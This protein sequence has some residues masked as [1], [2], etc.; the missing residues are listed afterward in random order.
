MARVINPI[1]IVNAKLGAVTIDRL[2]MVFAVEYDL[3]GITRANITVQAPPED[4]ADF[5]MG[6]NSRTTYPLANNVTN[7]VDYVFSA[8]PNLTDIYIFSL[9]EVSIAA[10]AFTGLNSLARIWVSASLLDTYKTDYPALSS[11]FVSV[12]EDYTLNIPYIA[13]EST[14]LTLEYFMQIV[15]GL[16][17]Q[18]KNAI[19][20]VVFD[21]DFTQASVDALVW[22][23]NFSNIFSSLEQNIW[24]GETKYDFSE[25]EF[26]GSGQ[27]T[28]QFVEDT[29]E[30]A[31]S[32]DKLS[33]IEK[34]TVPVDFTSYES[35]SIAKIEELFTNMTHLVTTYPDGILD[36]DFEDSDWIEIL[37]RVANQ[38]KT[39]DSCLVSARNFV[40]TNDKITDYADKENLCIVPPRVFNGNPNGYVSGLTSSTANPYVV[41]I[42]NQTITNELGFQYIMWSQSNLYK[43]EFT[44]K[45]SILFEFTSENVNLIKFNWEKGTPENQTFNQNYG[46][47]RKNY[48][49]IFN[50]LT[51]SFRFDSTVSTS[52][53]NTTAWHNLIVSLGTPTTTQTIT[54]APNEL[55]K[56]AQEDIALAQS[57]N[58]QIVTA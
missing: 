26:V 37:S 29:L 2:G 4:V 39:L 12:I 51:S 48:N 33:L 49:Y 31:I 21:D 44:F 40:N 17:S 5:L 3:D 13:G 16:T 58:W 57:K 18:Q 22:A 53:L 46:I 56:I 34:L 43:C 55:S 1:R 42:A 25:Y 54:V 32:S 41:Y 30:N 24:Y 38:N 19:T 52:Y 27:L 50:G 6:D 20:K 23:F 47:N 36:I 11:K 10:N 28:V 14:I 15:N 9:T 8:F 7:L 35:G 45:E